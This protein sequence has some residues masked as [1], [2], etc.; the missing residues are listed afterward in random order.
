MMTITLEGLSKQQ[1][2]IADLIWSCDT[3]EDVDR[4][5]QNL[6]PEYQRDAVTVHELMIAAVMDQYQEGITEDVQAIIDRCRG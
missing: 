6:P 4:L 5:I 1:H 3:Q 2:Q